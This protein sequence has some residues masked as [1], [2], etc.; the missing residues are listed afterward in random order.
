MSRLQ[1]LLPVALSA[2]LAACGGATEVPGGVRLLA[3]IDVDRAPWLRSDLVGADGRPLEVFVDADHAVLRLELERDA[4]RW[5]PALG[6]WE[7]AGLPVA[8]S[9]RGEALNAATLVADGQLFEPFALEEFQLGRTLPSGRFQLGGGHLRLRLEDGQ[10]PPSRA[11]LELALARGHRV[12]GGWRLESGRFSGDGLPLWPGEDFAL[13]VELDGAR[14]LSFA[15]LVE[16]VDN[17]AP[18]GDGTV[19]FRV[20]LDGELLHE[21]PPYSAR[22]FALEAVR[23][24]LPAAGAARLRF[25]VEGDFALTSIVAPRLVPRDVGRPGAR[26]WTERRPDIVVLQADTFRAD[27]LDVY[28]GGH[29]VTP[30]LDELAAD[31]LLFEVARSTSTYTLTAHASLFTGHYPVRAGITDSFRRLPEIHETVAERLAAAGYRTGAITDGVLVSARFGLDQGFEWY[32]E[33]KTGLDRTLERVEEF[34][35]LDDGRPTFLFIQTYRAHSP[36]VASPAARAAVGER[37]AIDGDFSTWFERYTRSFDGDGPEDERRRARSEAVER[38]RALYLGGAFDVDR[39]LERI[40]GR[41]EREG[42]LDDGFLVFTSDHGETFVERPYTFHAGPA[43]DEQLRVPLFLRGPGVEPRRVAAP[44]SWI[45][46]APTL[47]ALAG[48]PTPDEWPGRDLFAVA[49]DRSTPAR[50]LFAFQVG[51]DAERSTAA[52]IADERKVLVPEARAAIDAGAIWRSFDLARD[53]GEHDDVT[54]R[55]AWPRALL[56]R[57]RQRLLEAL[58]PLAVGEPVSSNARQLERLER[59]GYVDAAE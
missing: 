59:L 25:E 5:E 33:G 2:G 43:F 44:V 20:L 18:V 47:V 24:E 15:A 36:F 13:D 27:N 52:I 32:R 40:H 31:S 50:T 29:R 6:T 17:L 42:L 54:A 37:L 14:T 11:S 21:S 56:E 57:E 8:P 26:P 7:C 16:P 28:G 4:W 39:G 19:T 41:L 35:A 55:A 58:E 46:L 48:L 9:P 12:D 3:D 51:T 30:F 45:D 34:L 53:P 10:P 38:L 23:I 22:A 1:Q 49:A